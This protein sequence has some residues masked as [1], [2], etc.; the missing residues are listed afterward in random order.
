MAKTLRPAKKH[1]SAPATSR[2]NGTSNGHSRDKVTRVTR[3]GIKTY[4]KA[5]KELAKH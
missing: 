5:M 4:E 2:S 1:A 3:I